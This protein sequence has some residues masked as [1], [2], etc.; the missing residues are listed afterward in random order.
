M[1][2]TRL[3]KV[4][5]AEC[6]G[7]GHM[8]VCYFTTNPERKLGRPTSRRRV[9]SGRVSS[10]RTLDLKWIHVAEETV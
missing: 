8:C 4:R 1:S 5:V 2:W 10:N 3:Y 7:A 9:R 6:T